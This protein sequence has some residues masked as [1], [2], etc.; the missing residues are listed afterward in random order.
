MPGDNYRKDA[1]ELQYQE[2]SYSQ[3]EG[4]GLVI[5]RKDIDNGKPFDWGRTSKDYGK[6][7]DIY[8]ESFYKNLLSLGI[9]KKGQT[10][11]DLGTGTGVLPRGLYPY[12]AKFIGTD[13]SSEQ[14]EMAKSISKDQ[15]MDIDYYVCP[16][17]ATHMPSDSFDVITACQCFLYFDKGIV[18]PEIKRMLK[19]DGVFATMWMAWV[20]DEDEVSSLSEQLILK[21]NPD[22]K[23]AGYKR[24][25][26][27]ASEWDSYGFRINDVISYDEE[28]CFDIDS[29]SGRIR[30]CRGI[31]AS[32]PEDRIREFDKEHREA[33]LK[34]FGN[35]FKVLHHI[36][37][38]TLKPQS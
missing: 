34:N 19:K 22:W 13:I 38:M 26:A 1:L 37:I 4:S 7:R 3:P 11:L 35:A 20:P 25:K 18:L 28:L 2:M 32:L 15:G 23:G 9:G 24:L 31:G 14:I 16:A 29:W 10:I 8:P 6:Y 12:G 27:N 36:L 17:E 30:A 21:Y 33:L 5:H